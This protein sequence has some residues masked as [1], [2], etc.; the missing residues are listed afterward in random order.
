MIWNSLSIFIFEEDTILLDHANSP[1]DCF[2]T[3]KSIF[4]NYETK[5][6]L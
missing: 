6:T 3:F 5:A 1:S 2:V 4:T